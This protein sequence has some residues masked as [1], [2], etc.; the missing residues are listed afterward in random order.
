MARRVR[1]ADRS[2]FPQVRL[3]GLAECGTHAIFGA[4]T[5]PYGA[6]EQTLARRLVGQLGP[7]MLCLADRGF[8][9]VPLFDAARATGADLLWRAKS[10]AV[11]PVLERFDDGSFRSEIV[12][13]PDK[14]T[15]R[16]RARRASHRVHH[17]RP[18]PARHAGALPAADHDPGP[19]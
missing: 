15:L 12:A 18:R 10:N 6:A 5:G 3:V 19:G 13:T 14:R 16:Q 9:G 4:A 17:R 1:H 7:G 11:L 8:A 2:A